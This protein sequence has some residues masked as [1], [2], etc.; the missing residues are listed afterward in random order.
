MVK[1]YR[2]SVLDGE[3]KVIARV[4]YNQILDYWNGD[5]WINGGVGMHK[6]LTKLKTGEYVLIIGTQ[7]QGSKD[8][9]EIITADQAVKEILRSQNIYLLKTKKFKELKALADQYDSTEDDEY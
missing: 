1:E 3:H 5:N 9:A 4:R 6:G 2:V 8:Y 7:W